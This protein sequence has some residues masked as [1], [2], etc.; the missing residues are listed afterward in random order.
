MCVCVCVCTP[1]GVV[2]QMLSSVDVLQSCTN[3]GATITFRPRIDVW[4]PHTL[5]RIMFDETLDD[6]H[7]RAKKFQVTFTVNNPPSDHD[8]GDG[9]NNNTGDVPPCTAQFPSPLRCPPRPLHTPPLPRGG[10]N[11]SH[12]VVFRSLVVASTESVPSWAIGVM[13][14]LGAIAC[15]SAAVALQLYVQRRRQLQESGWFRI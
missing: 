12:P 4:D 8:S 9:D 7:T 6:S 13:I 5:V 15:M 1:C 2:W 14:L 3:Y 11:V 10:S